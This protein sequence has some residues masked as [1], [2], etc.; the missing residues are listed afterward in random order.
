MSKNGYLQKLDAYAELK[1]QRKHETTVQFMT[2]LYSIVLNDPDVLHE[3][4]LS[5]EDIENVI[6][7]VGVYYDHYVEALQETPES[8]VRQNELDKRLKDIFGPKRFAKFENRYPW[9]KVEKY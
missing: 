7:A 4:A 1:V 6:L 9:V 8:D 3:H 5:G 2:D